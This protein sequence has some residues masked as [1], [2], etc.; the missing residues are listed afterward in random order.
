VDKDYPKITD[1]TI[2]LVKDILEDDLE[3]LKVKD[4]V[5][6]YIDAAIE[7]LTD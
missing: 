3:N 1:F 4:Q 2:E 6:T 7:I 5:I